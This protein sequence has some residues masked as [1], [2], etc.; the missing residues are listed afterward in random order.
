MKNKPRIFVFYQTTI[1]LNKKEFNLH[2][3]YFSLLSKRDKV[4]AA[5]VNQVNYTVDTYGISKD[6]FKIIYNGVNTDHFTS[7]PA[8]WDRDGF[9]AQYGIPSSAKL[10]VM[11]AALRPE[12]NHTGALEALQILENTHHIK[13]YLLIAGGGIMEQEIRQH[14]QQRG[15]TSR[16]IL[17]GVQKDVRPVFWAAD[18]FTLCSTSVETFS[19]AALE[20]MS[21]GLPCVLTN[22][23]GAKE[24]IQEGVTGHVCETPAADI[25]AA[26]AKTLTEPYSTEAM[27]AYIVNNFSEPKMMAAYEKIF[28]EKE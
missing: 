26:W 28:A 12:K 8:N 18:L 15:L 16:A 20:A 5:S 9:R 10:I 7:M 3:F 11:A 2:K 6:F 25:A 17:A 14:I 22:I 21:C 13:A 23:G 4:I 27:H 24:M 1:H 19:V